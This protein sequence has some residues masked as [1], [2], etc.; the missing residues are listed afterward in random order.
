MPS[1]DIKQRIAEVLIALGISPRSIQDH[2]CTLRVEVITKPTQ[3]Q[4]QE[5][6]RILAA[7]LGDAECLVEAE[8]IVRCIGRAVAATTSC[9]GIEIYL[10]TVY[11][12]N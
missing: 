10:K 7:K 12:K 1:Q 11:E 3:E 6:A 5:F 4:I 8:N 9:I 2:G